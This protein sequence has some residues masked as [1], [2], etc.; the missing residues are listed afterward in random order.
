M[1]KGH[2]THK[3]KPFHKSVKRGH[4]REKRVWRLVPSVQ[5]VWPREFGMGNDVHTVYAA[6]RVTRGMKL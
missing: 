4:G 5:E 1:T 6:E 3:V 2:D